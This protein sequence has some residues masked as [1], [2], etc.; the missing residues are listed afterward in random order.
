MKTVFRR[1]ARLEDRFELEKPRRVFRM[2]VSHAA[3]GNANL[4]IATC[5]RY[6]WSDGTLMEYINLNGC[7]KSGITNEELDRFVERFPITRGR[8]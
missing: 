1:L 6:F 7:S 3:G 4:E 5:R 8:E 2:L